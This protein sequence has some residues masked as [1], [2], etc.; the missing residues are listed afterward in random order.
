MKKTTQT[1]DQLL[2]DLKK[3][4]R[5]ALSRLITLLFEDS[6]NLQKKLKN[7]NI[8]KSYA[9]GI[10]GP[11]GA[12]KSTLID[13]LIKT[14]RENKFTL[15]VIA[16]DPNSPFTGGAILGDRIRMQRHSE[17]KGVYIRSL[18]SKGAS[19]GLSYYTEDVIT[20][21]K[22]YGFDYI[23]VESIG[24]GQ[25]EI[26][27]KNLANTV[28]VVQVPEGGDSVQIL[29][30]G[31][32]EIADIFVINKSDRD[33]A[34]AMKEELKFLVSQNKSD[35]EI[36]VI[37][38]IAKDENGIDELFRAILV[39]QNFGKKSTKILDKELFKSKVLKELVELIKKN[40]KINI[41]NNETKN[42]K[43]LAKAIYKK[44]LYSI[45]KI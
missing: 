11:P 12:G 29:K 32:L 41:K 24:V 23:L 4:D 17:D 13:N 1:I 14:F 43:D 42:P 31:V 35:W 28:I 19:G 45:L 5:R 40:I 20:L 9:I 26:D 44:H 27:I 2:R 25:D 16:I 6:K 21:F 34:G 8:E 38:T 33:G 15:G 39:H 30:A 7:F 3:Q 37:S 22:I 36:P 10:T 18:G